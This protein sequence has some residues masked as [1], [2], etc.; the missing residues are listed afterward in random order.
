MRIPLPSCYFAE[1][2]HGAHLVIDGVQRITTV[3]R[4]MNDDFA[5]EEMTAFP[6]LNGKRFSHLGKY[7][8]DIESTTIRCIILRNENPKELITEIFAR[9]NQGAVKLSDQ[10]IRHA[11][12]P[13]EFDKLLHRLAEIE[14]VK[15]FGLGKDGKGKRDSREGEELVLRYFAFREDGANYEGNLS[16][17]L[18]GYMKKASSFEENKLVELSGK[19][20]A[21]LSSCLTIFDE[22]EVFADISKERRRQGVVYYDLLMNTLGEIDNDILAEKR[23]QIRQAFIDLCSSADFKRLTAGGLQRKSSISRRNTAWTTKLQEAIGD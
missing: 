22:N 13:G 14:I 3:L 23:G 9:L 21:S 1:D 8:S 15:N 17:F 16:K 4:F 20:E 5:L 7:R 12:F 18:D 10:E 19:F 6:E 11:L 2:D